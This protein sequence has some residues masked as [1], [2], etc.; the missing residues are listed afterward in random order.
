MRPTHT[1]PA[2][3][4]PT[5]EPTVQPVAETQP[6][7]AAVGGA[8]TA[9]WM[10]ALSDGAPEATAWPDWPGPSPTPEVTSPPPLE[11]LPPTETL[12][13]D[14]GP[15]VTDADGGTL[16]VYDPPGSTSLL[17]TIVGDVVSAFLGT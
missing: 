12:P 13:P 17:D 3:I 2:T 7:G 11:T 15:L 1:P 10:K 8:V 6:E 14:G 9:I 5:A 4:E 16:Q